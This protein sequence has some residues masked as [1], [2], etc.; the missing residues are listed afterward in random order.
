MKKALL[1][2]SLFVSSLSFAQ[3]KAADT[4]AYK[5]ILDY[6]V[7]SSPAF[8]VLD[9]TPQQVTRGSAAKPLVLN[10]F[11]NFL[12]T[13]KLDPGV[14]VDFS[15]YILLG[16]GFKNLKEYRDNPYK[17]A[18]ANSMVSL[19]ALKNS[20]DSTNTD[21]GLGIRLNLFDDRDLF[22]N[23]ATSVSI[24]DKIGNALADAAKAQTVIGGVP[25][26]EIGTNG[27]PTGTVTVDMDRFYTDAYNS[28]RN[29]KG[30]ALS[31]GFG[32][33][34]TA[35][36]SVLDAD[37]LINKQSKLWISSTRYTAGGFD[38][39]GILQG[40]FSDDAK[41]KWIG[42]LAAGSKNK[43]SNLGAELVY[44]FSAKQWNYGGNFEIRILKQFTY[45]VSFGKRSLLVNGVDVISTFR[46]IS[47]LR[48]DLFGH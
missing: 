48:L 1:I 38:I 22:A 27:S 9:V 30:W 21:I 43:K 24:T 19:A 26:D 42:G 28:L 46:V 20:K 10:A 8:T 17:R 39:F 32:Y 23:S 5:F 34:A 33:R 6:A 44:D 15:P 40:S 47:N 25:D 13:G 14:A 11:T 3:K 12:Q 29:V 31:V 2:I 37:S 45:L 7:P 4:E 18:L 35:K 41:S 36:S 16:G